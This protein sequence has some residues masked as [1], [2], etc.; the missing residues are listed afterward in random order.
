MTS[1]VHVYSFS[2]VRAH[3]HIH[4]CTHTHT[5]THTHRS[6]IMVCLNRKGMIS[7]RSTQSVCHQT[8][9]WNIVQMRR[10][11]AMPPS[12]QARCMASPC[13]WTQGRALV[14]RVPWIRPVWSSPLLT[15]TVMVT[16]TRATLTSWP[17]TE[18]ATYPTG[19]SLRYS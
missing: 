13:T 17:V 10:V 7:L 12:H 16:L 2:N 11:S 8:S 15:R 9:T 18:G 4:P 6:I 19:M 14:P 3:T 1:A 5:H